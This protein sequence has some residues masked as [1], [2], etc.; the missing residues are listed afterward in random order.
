MRSFFARRILRATSKRYHYDVSYLDY[1]LKESPGAFFKFAGLAKASSHREA[2][3]VEASFA[4]KI[5]GAPVACLSL[6]LDA[7]V[8]LDAVSTLAYGT[9]GS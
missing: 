7:W 4:A 2:V 9:S 6:P 5:S 1:M 8:K 3:P